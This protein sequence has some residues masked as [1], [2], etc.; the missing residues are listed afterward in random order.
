MSTWVT[1]TCTPW[2][3]STAPLVTATPTITASDY[4][5]GSAVDPTATLIQSSFLTP[6]STVRTDANAGPFTDTSASGSTALTA[7]LNTAYAGGANAGD[8]VYLRLSYDVNQPTPDGNNAYAVLTSNAGGAEEKPQILFSS[9]LAQVANVPEPSS[10][11]TLGAG[12][13]ALLFIQRRRK[14]Q[15]VS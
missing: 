7:F 1:P 6:N 12:I 2:A 11:L 8:Y 15:S 3:L 13:A 5:Q 14:L 10:Y 4:Y 9:G